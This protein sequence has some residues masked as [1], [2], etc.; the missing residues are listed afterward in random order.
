MPWAGRE[1]WADRIPQPGR[2]QTAGLK[3]QPG[4][5]QQS[6]QKQTADQ[7]QQSGPEH[8]PGL[9]CG[10]SWLLPL[11]LLQVAALPLSDGE[12]VTTAVSP[13]LPD[14]GQTGPDQMAAGLHQAHIVLGQMLAVPV[15]P[16]AAPGSARRPSASRQSPV[17]HLPPCSE[18]PLPSAPRQASL[19]GAAAD[20]GKSLHI[21]RWRPPYI[22]Q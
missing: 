13:R 2:E 16:P 6:E 11:T 5:R 7:K 9:H 18:G 10:L 8:L 14:H 21:P 17:L 15:Q 20:T 3:Q 1:C 12:P 22:H 4:R 19:P